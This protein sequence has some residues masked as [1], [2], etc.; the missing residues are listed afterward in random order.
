MGRDADLAGLQA[1]IREYKDGPD[2]PVLQDFIASMRPFAPDGAAYD[3]FV[4]QWFRQVVVPEYRLADVKKVN[5][6]GGWTVTAKVTNIGT[7]RMPVEVAAMKGE[8]FGKDGTPS[9]D[10]KDARAALVLG[11]AESGEIAIRCGFE[12]E[13]IVIDPDARVL[14]LRRKAAESG[15]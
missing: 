14:Q 1:F 10:Y 9:A 3:D 5:D 8:R 12:P 4:D 13:K 2:Y 11:A 6:A 7:G 15:F